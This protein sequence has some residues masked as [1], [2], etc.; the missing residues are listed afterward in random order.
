MVFFD[1]NKIYISY[2]PK[3]IKY[4][5]VPLYKNYDPYKNPHRH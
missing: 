2:A 5:F 1:I 3:V 4:K